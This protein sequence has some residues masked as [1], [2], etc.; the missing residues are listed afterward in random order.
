MANWTGTLTPG[1]DNVIGYDNDVRPSVTIVIIMISVTL[2]LF[3]FKVAD[4]FIPVFTMLEF[5]FYMGWL[6]V[7]ET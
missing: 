6:K 5:F 7:G 4:F 1:A 3:F 2:S